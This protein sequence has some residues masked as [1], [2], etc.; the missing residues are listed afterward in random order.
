ML[1]NILIA[2]AN[3]ALVIGGAFALYL[4]GFGV[5]LILAFGHLYYDR[6]VAPAPKCFHGLSAQGVPIPSNDCYGG[7]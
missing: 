2:I 6:F 7:R 5:L 4:F 3:V 1:R